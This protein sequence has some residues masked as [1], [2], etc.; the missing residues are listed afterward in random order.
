MG[1]KTDHHSLKRPN[2]RG[3]GAG[4]KVAN[5]D[6]KL[7]QDSSHYK[8]DA[9]DLR[10][11]INYHYHYHSNGQNLPIVKWS[12]IGMTCKYWTKTVQYSDHHLNIEQLNIRQV[13][14]HYSDVCFTEPHCNW[15]GS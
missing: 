3:P 1:K 7:L 6:N 8:S 12:S 11:R 13:K 9:F 4:V 10:E 14:V 15:I 2:R 5:C